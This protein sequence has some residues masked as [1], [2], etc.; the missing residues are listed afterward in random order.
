MKA[1]KVMLILIGAVVL[2]VV[3]AGTYV[4]VALPDT[5]EPPKITVDR[6]PQR[7]ENGRYLANHVAV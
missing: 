3:A 1:L 6:G 5:G 7:I 2:L 4:K